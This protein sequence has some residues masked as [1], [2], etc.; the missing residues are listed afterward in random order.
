MQMR[1]AITLVESAQHTWAPVLK[2]YR[3]IADYIESIAGS[4][5]D[6]DSIVDYFRGAKAVLKR[7]AL[8]DLTQGDAASNMAVRGR[9]AKY[10]KLPPETMPPLVVEGGKV[11]DGNHRYRACVKNGVTEV[12]AY[13]VEDQ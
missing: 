3:E 11:V 4:D 1:K 6:Y 10:R 8:A 9:E 13:V 7:V 5:V 12:W 2:N